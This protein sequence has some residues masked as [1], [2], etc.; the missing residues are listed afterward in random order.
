MIVESVIEQAVSG[1]Q[2]EIETTPH[3]E[4]IRIRSQSVINQENQPVNKP[5][6]KKVPEAP[7]IP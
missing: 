1:Q 4:K 3:D 2:E 5:K 7:K 6:V